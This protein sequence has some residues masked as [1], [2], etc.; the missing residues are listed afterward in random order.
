MLINDGLTP[1]NVGAGYVLRMIVR[2]CYYN[3]I[4][5]KK[6]SADELDKFVEA[7]FLSFK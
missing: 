4:L 3:L 6:L 1:S 7:S 5:L 2:R